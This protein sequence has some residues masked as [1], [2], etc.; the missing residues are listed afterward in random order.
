MINIYKVGDKIKFKSEKQQYT[1]QACNE[2]FAVCTK[3]FNLMKTVLY[4]VIDFDRN[5]R[6]TE[7]LIFGMGAETREQCEQML[8]RLTTNETQVSSRNCMELDIDEKCRCKGTKT[9][10][11]RCGIP[12]NEGKI[13]CIKCGK[14]IIKKETK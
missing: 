14:V 3:P 10:D 6:G 2:K 8:V 7:N 4:S 12:F 9:T 5:I 13:S 1:V 11:E